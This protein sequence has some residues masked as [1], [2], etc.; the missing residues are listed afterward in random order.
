MRSHL[1]GRE[2][3]QRVGDRP[4][5]VFSC[6]LIA[7]GDA[8]VVAVAAAVTP[9]T[10]AIDCSKERADPEPRTWQGFLATGPSVTVWRC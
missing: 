5:S 3:R 8:L 4:V 2:R 1:A 10:A 9:A 7:L 6:V